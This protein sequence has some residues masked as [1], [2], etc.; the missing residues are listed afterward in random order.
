MF[1]PLDGN[2][3]ISMLSVC[4]YSSFEVRQPGPILFLIYTLPSGDIVRKHQK[5]YHLYADNT[6]LYVSFDSSTPSS[7]IDAITRLEA[8]ISDIHHWML[9]NKFKLNNDKTEFLKFLPQ[10]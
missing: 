2:L 5:D 3:F 9:E 4:V 6:Q 10:L 1:T 8:C 7:G